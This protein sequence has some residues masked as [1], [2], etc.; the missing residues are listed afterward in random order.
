MRNAAD[1]RRY[2][3]NAS[4]RG[5]RLPFLLCLL[6]ATACNFS[7]SRPTPTK[8]DK[9]EIL[10]AAAA[11]LQP[12]FEELGRVFAAEQGINVRFSFGST[13]NLTRQIENGLPADL[14][15]AANVAFIERLEQQGLIIADT[16]ALYARG[17]IALWMREDAPLT[18][19]TLADLARPEVRR[20]AI[21]NPEHAPYGLAAK[22]ALQSLKL[23]EAVA[24]K[25][26]Y[27]ENV[28]QATQFAETGNADVAITALSLS[29]QS[30]GRW[31]LIAEDLHQPLHQALAVIKTTAHERQARQFTAFL[32]SPRGQEIMQRYGFTK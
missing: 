32:A 10:V 12:A 24:P 28:R 2:D 23:W 14:F 31:R 3:R 20:V 7:C 22:E 1:N 4:E 26:V 27:G 13:G 15:A 21:A 8:A 9:A 17:R 16:K 19:E 5:R 11:D 6:L 18:V 25:L 30:R 29:L